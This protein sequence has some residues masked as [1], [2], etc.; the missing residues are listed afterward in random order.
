M[1]KYVF[2]LIIAVLATNLTGFGWRTVPPH[3]LSPSD[4]LRR[5]I[6]P[7]TGLVVAPGFEYVRV[8][9]VS[10]HSS[11]LVTQY[12]A[13][14]E[15][16]EERIRWMQAKHNLWQLGEIEPAILDYLAKYYPPTTQ[17]ERRAPLSSVQWY[18]LKQ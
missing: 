7:E 2:L 18:K 5:S 12:R 13:T 14:R 10:C 17:T 6:D 9:C 11:K 16:W 1:K 8:H 4:S 15:R 3:Q